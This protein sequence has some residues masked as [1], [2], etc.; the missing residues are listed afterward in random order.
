LG[1]Q[2]FQVFLVLLTAGCT[3]LMTFSTL[4][5][6]A[7]MRS[8]ARPLFLLCHPLPSRRPSPSSPSHCHC[9]FHHRCRRAIHRHFRHRCHRCAAHCHRLPLPLP[10]PLSHHHRAFCRRR[11]TITP[12]VVIAVVLPL[13]HPSPS[14]HPSPLPPHCRHTPLP[15]LLLAPSIAVAVAPVVSPSLRLLLPSCCHRA[16]H[17][18]CGCVAIAP[19]ITVAVAPSIAVAIALPSHA[20]AAPVA[21]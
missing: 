7:L 2:V 6:Q 8:L 15:L 19:S 12:S 21:S 18:C 5:R 4:L 9:A 11:V 3:A 14:R 20:F 17:H 13:R 1:V 16:V 10:S